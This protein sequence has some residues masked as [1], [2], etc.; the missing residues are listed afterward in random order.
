MTTF[1]ITLTTQTA[2]AVTVEMLTVAATQ[3]AGTHSREQSTVTTS[4]LLITQSIVIIIWARFSGLTTT[5]TNH[6]FLAMTSTLA[7]FTIQNIV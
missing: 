7:N 3:A 5:R 2:V 6:I 1:P 4:T